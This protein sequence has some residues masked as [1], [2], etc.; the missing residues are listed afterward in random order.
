[1]PLWQPSF[2]AVHLAPACRPDRSGFRGIG[3]VGADPASLIVNL[4]IVNL[5]ERADDLRGRAAARTAVNAGLDS[6]DGAVP[7]FAPGAK[8]EEPS[9]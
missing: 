6:A 8:A 3:L 2:N 9:D 1:M 4:L 5:L 7:V